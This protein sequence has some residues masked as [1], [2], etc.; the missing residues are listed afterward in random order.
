MK[1]AI[2]VVG[3]AVLAATPL[4]LGQTPVFVSRRDV[5]RV[6]VLVTERGRSVLGLKASDF[7][8]LDNG[9]PG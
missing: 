2:L 7:T 6:D 9:V 8:V 1:S 5:V 3:A 4:P